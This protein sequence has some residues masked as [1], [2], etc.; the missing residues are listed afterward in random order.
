MEACRPITHVD[1][2]PMPYVTE[3]SMVHIVLILRNEEE[4]G[5]TEKFLESYAK[6]MMAKSD[7]SELSL[8]ILNQDSKNFKAIAQN[9]NTMYKKHGSRIS[10]IT[11]KY[12]GS[13]NANMDFIAADLLSSKVGPETLLFVCNPYTQIFPDVLNRVRINTIAG[14]QIFSPIPFAEY[15]PDVSFPGLAKREALNIS[16]NQGF[17]DI[18]DSEHL[19]FYLADYLNGIL[20]ENFVNK[21]F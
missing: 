13:P 21:N 18:N 2:V 7:K 17:Y 19:S 6:N 10:I 11:Y 16:T 9:L 4:V 12:S 20:V 14:W 5:A 1:T 15:N 3:S 8:I